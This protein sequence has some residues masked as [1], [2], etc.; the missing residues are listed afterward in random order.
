[1]GA[2]RSASCL[3]LRPRGAA[4]VLVSDLIAERLAQARSLGRIAPSI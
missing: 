1:M 2:G 3:L 4:K